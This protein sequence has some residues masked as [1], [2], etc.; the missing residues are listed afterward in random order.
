LGSEEEPVVLFINTVKLRR[1]ILKKEFL[2]QV[3]QTP[4]G[5]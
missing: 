4:L 2:T 5:V 3:L 1:I